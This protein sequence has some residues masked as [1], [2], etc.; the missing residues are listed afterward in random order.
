M[1]QTFKISFTTIKLYT[2]RD[3]QSF[4]Y[5]LNWT[6][7]ITMLDANTNITETFLVT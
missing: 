3:R 2:L 1:N 5:F 4:L 7:G 6:Q